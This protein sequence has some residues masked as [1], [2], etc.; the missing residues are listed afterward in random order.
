MLDIAQVLTEY[1]CTVKK[2]IP[3]KK[4]FVHPLGLWQ[5]CIAEQNK[6]KQI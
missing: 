1:L 4:T 2:N 6:T 3:Q 5:N